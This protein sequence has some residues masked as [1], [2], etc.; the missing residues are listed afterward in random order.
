MGYKNHEGYADPTA[1]Y[2]E[3]RANRRRK[4]KRPNTSG[5]RLS[6]LYCFRVAARIVKDGCEEQKGFYTYAGEG[7]TQ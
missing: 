6:E 7:R 5:Y 2:G 1:Y 4:K 3:K